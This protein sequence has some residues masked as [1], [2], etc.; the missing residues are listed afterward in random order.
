MGL[1]GWSETLGCETVM[2]RS[3]INLIWVAA[4][5]VIVGV[6]VVGFDISGFR[7]WELPFLVL[8]CAILIYAL[9]SWHP[10]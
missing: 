8:G 4:V 1:Q 9:F 7:V 3:G 6:L 10:S 2:K 5:I